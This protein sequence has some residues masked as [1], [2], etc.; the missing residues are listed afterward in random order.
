[1]LKVPKISSLQYL[2]NISRKGI[3]INLIF[4]MKLYIKVFYKL[5]PSFLIAILRHA[6]STI[7]QSFQYL[8]KDRR[9]EVDFLHADM[10]QTFLQVDAINFG[11]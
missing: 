3:G 2:S 9:D 7:S 1:M 8:K 6:E 10:G 5:M 4:S 11:L